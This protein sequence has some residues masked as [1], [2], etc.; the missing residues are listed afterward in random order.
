MRSTMLFNW[1]WCLISAK[2]PSTK[3][4]V[5]NMRSGGYPG[6]HAAGASLYQLHDEELVLTKGATKTLMKLADGGKL[7]DDFT[8]T[9]KKI[10]RRKPQ[11]VSRA[12]WKRVCAA[13]GACPPKPK[14]AARGVSK[15]KS[16]TSRRSVSR[17]KPLSRAGPHLVSVPVPNPLGGAALSQR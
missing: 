6:T 8:R 4:T 9:L 14:A 12:E 10:Y 15:K 16:A 7:P 3:S 1:I 2:Q 17:P 11:P 5:I 13:Q